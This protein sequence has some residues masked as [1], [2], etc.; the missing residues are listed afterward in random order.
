MGERN[1][2]INTKRNKLPDLRCIIDLAAVFNSSQ[3]EP[4]IIVTAW[5]ALSMYA[6]SRINETLTL[7]VNCERYD[8]VSDGSGHGISWLPEKGGD[9]LVKR[10]ASE[11]SAMIARTAIQRL[12]D[13][14]SNARKTA[15]WYEE[16]PNSLYLPKKYEHLRGEPL[17]LYEMGMIIGRGGRIPR[18]NRTAFGI[19]STD[20]ISFDKTRTNS[21][22]RSRL[23]TFESLERRVL[24]M[25]PFGWPYA[26]QKNKLKY[27]EALFTMPRNI[28][29]GKAATFTNIPQFITPSIIMHELGKKPSGNTIFARNDL[30]D[31][32]TGLPWKLNSHQP[33]HLLNTIAQS[34]HL[35]Q[36]LIAFWSGRKSVK[37]ND[38]YDHTSQE[39]IIEAYLK[40]E[41]N[42]PQELIV[43]GPLES[44]VEERNINEPITKDEA[45]KDE[46]AAFHITKYGYCRHDFSLTPCPKDKWCNNCGEAYFAKGDARQI[47]IAE[48]DVTKFT[49]SLA[50]AKLAKADGEYGVEQW[51]E[52]LELDLYRASLKLGKLTDPDLEDGTLITLPPPAVSQSK[53]GLSI[54]IRDTE[55]PKEGL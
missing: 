27:S 35:S 3:Y 34:K 26:D 22:L 31:P 33:R 38:Y 15:S 11:E 32:N 24:S 8:N 51:I 25:L 43:T 5:F 52:K 28:M 17:T 29:K 2:A 12:I 48:Q 39:F 42:A 1:R 40:L 13:L 50:T 53:A 41:E 36:E 10:A 54:A 45:L 20:L 44:K 4:D 16:N 49:K 6:P 23:F 14:G 46:L 18:N 9:P 21:T 47:K 55:N 7:H 37:Q 30:V 19:E